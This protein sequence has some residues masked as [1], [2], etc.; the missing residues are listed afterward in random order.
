MKRFCSERKK[1]FFLLGMSGKT[2]GM[3]PLGNSVLVKKKVREASEIPFFRNA[4]GKRFFSVE[5]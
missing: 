5:V 4:I 2:G 3:G 1:S